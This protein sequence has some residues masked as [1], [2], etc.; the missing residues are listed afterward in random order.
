MPFGAIENVDSYVPSQRFYS[1]LIDMA[2]RE[3][4]EDLGLNVG[5]KF[6]ADNIDPKM[7]MLL[8][9]SPSLFQGILKASDL[10]NG[11]VSQIKMGILLPLHSSSTYFYFYPSCGSVHPVVRH[12]GWFGIQILIGIVR[13]FSGPHW[14]PTEIGL[15]MQN[16]P[17]RGI[18]EQFRNV[19]M[20]VSRPCFYIK[21]PKAQL[22][23]PP[24]NFDAAETAFNFEHTSDDFVSSLRQTLHAYV[25]ERDLSI[26]FAA[27]LCLISKR[28][29]QRKLQNMGTCY[30]E[31]LD[32]ARFDVASRMLQ[33]PNM[34][35][36]N[37]AHRLRYSNPTHF[38]RAF[39]RIAG[40]NPR[41][42]RKA[43]IR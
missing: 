39:R 42:Y 22:G 31:V 11:S 27:E 17:H 35:V 13:V 33:D 36:L 5:Q 21:I 4:I 23:I 43:H 19:R 28:S 16:G 14:Q 30:S 9:Q 25:E 38:S 10:G 32:M 3:G 15:M 34:N 2:R 12:I 40:L 41:D 6:G 8:R 24:L 37:V 1:F 29:L 18:R 26:E 20:R 7:S